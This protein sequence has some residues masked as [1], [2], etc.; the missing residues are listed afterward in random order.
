VKR[1]VIFLF[2][3]ATG[4]S[5]GL[6]AG[7][8]WSRERRQV[9]IAVPEPA[10]PQ[11][12]PALTES[13]PNHEIALA[14]QSRRLEQHEETWEPTDNAAVDPFGTDQA[15]EFKQRTKEEMREERERMVEYHH[16]QAVFPD[17]ASDATPRLNEAL[18]AVAAE[19]H[20]EVVDTDCRTN[21]CLAT[22]VWDDYQAAMASMKKTLV[23]VDGVNCSVGTI[24]P[25]PEDPTAPYESNVFFDNCELRSVESDQE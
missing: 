11:K 15:P 23:V 1:S 3:F 9:A 18:T 2:V 25:P 5:F 10:H 4:L 12:A 24:L 19:A 20:F 16:E 6:A 14:A 17:F 13:P 22:L 8:S 7:G 21:S